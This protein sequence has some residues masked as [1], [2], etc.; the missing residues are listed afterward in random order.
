M[1]TKQKI[2]K[3]AELAEKMSRMQFA[4]VADYRG[5]TVADM[6]ELRGKLRESGAEMIVAKNTLLLIAARQTGKE[7]I[8]PLL[9]GPT[10]VTFAYDDAAKTAKTIQEYV[11]SA[12]K[13]F[14]VRGGLLGTTFLPAD[15]IAEV[16]KMPSREE[17]LAQVVGGIQAPLSGIVGVIGA[18]ASDVVGIL[19]AVTSDFVGVLQA[20]IHQLQEA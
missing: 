12:S 8:E 4:I 18:P 19:N 9:E 20:R 10:A 13:P 14:T 7:A 2:A 16:T 11:K 6:E 15:G 1:P 17:V 3:V 5:M